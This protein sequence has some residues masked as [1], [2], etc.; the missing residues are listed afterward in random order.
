MNILHVK[1]IT[2]TH[3]RVSVVVSGDFCR[4]K[5]ALPSLLFLSK[6]ESTIFR[7]RYYSL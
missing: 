5:L 2:L 7:S 4:F 3:I 6:D 1:S